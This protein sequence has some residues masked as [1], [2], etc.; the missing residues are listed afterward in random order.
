MEQFSYY[1][2][3]TMLHSLWQTAL[4]LLFYGAI[5][6]LKPRLAPLHKR[7]IL[8]SLLLVQVLYSVVT[9]YL[10][11]NNTTQGLFIIIADSIAPLMAQSWLQGNAY[12][13]FISYLLFIAGRTA[14][15]CWHW[16]SF[17]KG[18]K[19]SLLKASL[20]LRL[21]TQSKAFEFGISRKVSLWCSNYISTPMT[22]GFWKPVILLPMAL[23]N[24]LSMEQ[25][26]A[27]IIHEL[28]HIRHKDYLLNWGLIIAETLFF[29]NPFVRFIAKQI[30]M[31]R[32]K[33]CDVQVLHFK[34]GNILYAEALLTISQMQHQLSVQVA[35]VKNKKQLFQRISFF[36]RPENLQF[37]RSRQSIFATGYLATVVIT[38]LLAIS[39]TQKKLSTP[40]APKTQEITVTTSKTVTTETSAAFETKLAIDEKEAAIFKQSRAMESRKAASAER[41][42]LVETA[43]YLPEEEDAESYAMPASNQEINVEGKEIIIKDEG[44][45]GKKV[46][47]AY[48]ALLVDGVWTLQPLWLISETSPTTDSLTIK[49]K[50]SILNLIKR[51]Q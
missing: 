1:F 33:N 28:T 20:D 19:K 49:S 23:V 46:T 47:A 2:I 43:A 11:T 16:G 7:N 37:Q 14:A 45:D 36:T 26:E 21:F 42:A 48:Y 22:F 50:D 4:L 27:L 40:L 34:Y 35:A 25:T 5:L 30:K 24:Q 38:L 3:S 13:I 44:S 15:N 41:N 39:F 6:L 12:I 31:E 8:L 32:E 29:F 18:Y 9:F 51:I 17:K 10:L